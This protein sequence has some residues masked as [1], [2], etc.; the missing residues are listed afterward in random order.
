MSNQAACP[1]GACALARS[2]RRCAAGRR[3]QLASGP[4][5]RQTIAFRRLVRARARAPTGRPDNFF[6]SAVAGA[7]V[8]GVGM[9]ASDTQVSVESVGNLE[10]RMTFTP[11][12]RA[13]GD[14]GR[15]SPARNRAHR[16]HQ[17]LPP[18]QGADQGRSSSAT[19]SRC[20]PKSSDGMLREGFD[21]AIRE[22]ALRLAGNPQIKPADAAERGRPGLHRHV[23]GGAG[24]R[25]HR[26]RQAARSSATPPRSTTPTSTA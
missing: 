4:A 22:N 12:G 23:R 24:F 20:A 6:N 17:G 1:H 3:L 21:S 10:R 5:I 15:Q 2:R 26:R 25:R 13:P 8:A 16:A 14:P 11:A 7:A 18:R 9:P 19:A